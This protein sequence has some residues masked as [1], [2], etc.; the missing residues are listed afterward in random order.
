MPPN[1]AL[2]ARGALRHGVTPTVPEEQQTLLTA[3]LTGSLVE[4][5]DPTAANADSVV[6]RHHLQT[7]RALRLWLTQRR[8]R[9]S[10]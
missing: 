8:D 9:R 3:Q 6:G 1:Q 2:G 4:M 7:A 5:H 10:P